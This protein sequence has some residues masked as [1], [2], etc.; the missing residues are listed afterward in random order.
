MK[1]NYKRAGEQTMNQILEKIQEI[2]IVP[3]VV[4]NDAKDAKPLAEALVQGGLPCHTF[5]ANF[6]LV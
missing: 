1:L 4:L 3:V 2:G 5:A 6:S